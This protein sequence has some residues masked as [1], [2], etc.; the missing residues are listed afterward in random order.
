MIKGLDMILGVVGS[1][2]CILQRPLAADK[3]D[4]G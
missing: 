3:K 2:P 1:Q 4:L